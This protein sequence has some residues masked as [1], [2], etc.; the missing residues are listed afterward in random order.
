MII[1]PSPRQWNGRA[2][3]PW[4]GREDGLQ[5]TPEEKRWKRKM[6]RGRR[7]MNRG[8]QC[9]EG[10]RVKEKVKKENTKHKQGNRNLNKDAST[11]DD[12]KKRKTKV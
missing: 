6:R 9:L 2:Y 10:R 12:K 1:F 3:D 7:S 8:R 5:A 4:G 11:D